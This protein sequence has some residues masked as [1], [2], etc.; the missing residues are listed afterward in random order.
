MGAY[1]KRAAK[2]QQK[3]LIDVKHNQYRL[4]SK[5][6]NLHTRVLKVHIDVA[7]YTLIFVHIDMGEV[8]YS[9]SQTLASSVNRVQCLIMNSSSLWEEKLQHVSVIRVLLQK[10]NAHAQ[11]IPRA[12]E[13]SN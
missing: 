3:V 13:G 12:L 10:C 7:N 11:F 6:V 4:Q 8:P 2:H 1:A 9:H 5:Q